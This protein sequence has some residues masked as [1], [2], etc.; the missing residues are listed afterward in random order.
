MIVRDDRKSEN[1][2]LYAFVGQNLKV[3]LLTFSRKFC[4]QR[5]FKKYFFWPK[6]YFFSISLLMLHFS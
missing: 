5:N 3:C 1:V 6:I 2:L 4:L